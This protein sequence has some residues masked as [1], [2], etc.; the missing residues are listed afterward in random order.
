VA[1]TNGEQR[2]ALEANGWQR[3]SRSSISEVWAKGEFSI[4]GW[5]NARGRIDFTARDNPERL[6]EFLS[7]VNAHAYE[8]VD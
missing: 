8:E 4:F 6:A 2:Q 1:L 7:L 3:L 5:R